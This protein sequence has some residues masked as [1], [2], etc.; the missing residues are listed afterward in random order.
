[1]IKIKRIFASIRLDAST[2]AAK[3]AAALRQE[4]EE[5]DVSDRRVPL[6]ATASPSLARSKRTAAVRLKRD[7]GDKMD[8]ITSNRYLAMW[9][10]RLSMDGRDGQGTVAGPNGT[11]HKGRAISIRRSHQDPGFSARG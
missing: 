9:T 7:G 8:K 11:I 2:P 4:E 5:R 3:P 6:S 1:M 10:V